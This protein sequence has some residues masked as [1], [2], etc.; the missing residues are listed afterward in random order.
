MK[1]PRNFLE[2]HND[3]QVPAV[4]LN[5]TY[6]IPAKEV[7]EQLGYASVDAMNKVYLRNKDEFVENDVI[8]ATV[9]TPGGPQETR[10]Y[11]LEGIYALGMLAKTAPAKQ[12]RRVIKAIMKEL[13]ISGTVSLKRYYS[14][15]ELVDRF[16]TRAGL[17]NPFRLFKDTPDSPCYAMRKRVSVM[18]VGSKDETGVESIFCVDYWETDALGKF[19]KP[20]YDTYPP[21]DFYYV[22]VDAVKMFLSRIFGDDYDN[23]AHLANAGFYPYEDALFY[24]MKYHSLKYLSLPCTPNRIRAAHNER[25]AKRGEPVPLTIEQYNALLESDDDMPKHGYYL[26]DSNGTPIE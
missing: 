6:Y 20:M 17:E 16:S 7:A 19:K 23:N 1:E 2:L 8:M 9:Q 15:E 11:S 24:G 22:R 13:A 10:C 4:F 18:S 12:L 3:T 14:A 26:V 21:I 25:M 5:Q